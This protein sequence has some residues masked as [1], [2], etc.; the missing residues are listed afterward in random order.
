MSRTTTILSQDRFLVGNGFTFSAASVEWVKEVWQP[1]NK[2]QIGLASGKTIVMQDPVEIETFKKEFGDYQYLSSGRTNF[3]PNPNLFPGWYSLDTSGIIT[4]DDASKFDANWTIASTGLFQGPFIAHSARVDAG[5]PFWSADFELKFRVKL[6][7]AG[8]TPTMDTFTGL[9][10]DDI[11]PNQWLTLSKNTLTVSSFHISSIISAFKINEYQGGSVSFL[12]SG[13]NMQN[14]S[15]INIYV[16][17]YRTGLTQG[18]DIYVD[19]P[20]FTV[21]TDPRR[22]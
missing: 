7:Y 10:E 18:M 5:T 3:P 9:T 12:N 16:K 8:T 19:D 2:I 14:L 15:G 11:I 6:N 21:L 1:I 13:F 20:T 22:R 17:F 4:V